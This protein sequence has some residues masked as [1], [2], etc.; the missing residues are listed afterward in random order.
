ML[1][2][3]CHIVLT[4]L[5]SGDASGGGYPKQQQP[6]PTQQPAY[7]TQQPAYPTQP[8]AQYGGPPPPYQ[9]APQQAVAQPQQP[10]VHYQ[11]QG[12][13]ASFVCF[14]NYPHSPVV[15][16]ISMYGGHCS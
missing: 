4:L 12:M 16:A 1:A 8:S 6:Y 13:C 10:A 5:N 3:N 11:Y 15:H 7:P 2:V 14:G 9:P